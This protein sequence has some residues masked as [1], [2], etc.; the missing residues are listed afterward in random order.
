LRI[1]KW[2]TI[3]SAVSEDGKTHFG[4]TVSGKVG[5]AILRNKLK[6]WVR[7][8]VRTG[9]WPKKLS[10]TKSVCI[11]RPQPDDFYKQLDFKQFKSTLEKV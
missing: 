9:L 11:F 5:N 10:G 2:L 1:A 6:R 7:H 4:T 8:C 3:V